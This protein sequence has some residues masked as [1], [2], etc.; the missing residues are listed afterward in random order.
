MHLI[1]QRDLRGVRSIGLIRRNQMRVG[2]GKLIRHCLILRR[3]I[4]AV[5]V[6]RIWLPSNA[7]FDIYEQI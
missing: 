4:L 3:Q 7:M 1:S 5:R 6:T 2:E